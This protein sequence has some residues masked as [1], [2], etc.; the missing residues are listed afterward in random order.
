MSA[1]NASASAVRRPIRL[2]K[3]SVALLLLLLVGGVSVAAAAAPATPAPMTVMRVVAGRVD[4]D[5]P[6]TRR[7]AV[8]SRLVVQRDGQTIAELEVTILSDHQASCRIVRMSAPIAGGDLVVVAPTGQA[9]L[10][11]APAGSA[12]PASRA[13]PAPQADAAGEHPSNQAMIVQRVLRGAVDISLVD[14]QPVAV[15]D[16]LVVERGSLVIGELEVVLMGEH[17]ATCRIDREVRPITQGDRVRRLDVPPPAAAEATAPVAPVP[18]APV[19]PPPAVVEPE[20]TVPAPAVAP[21]VPGEPAVPQ[22][23]RVRQVLAEEIFLD[24]GRS[25]GLAAGQRVKI[26]RADPASGTTSEI[27]ELEIAF[28]ASHSASCKIVSASEP[29]AV[30][31]LVIPGPVPA[32]AA[33]VPA[34]G[35]TG[36]GGASATAPASGGKPPGWNAAEHTDYSG[37]L[38]LRFQGFKDGGPAGRDFNQES[39]LVNIYAGHIGGSKFDFRLRGTAS[40]EQIQLSSG[41]SDSRDNDRL[42]EATLSY[43][44]PEARFTYQVGRLISG[45]LVGFDYLDGGVGE[46]HVTQRFSLGAFYGSRSNGDQIDFAS[47]GRAYGAFVHWLDQGVGRPFYAE[48]LFEAIGDYLHGDTNREYLSFYGRQGSGSRW[49]LY[50]R[51]EF[52]LGHNWRDNPAANSNQLSNVLFSG[53][54]SVSKAVRLGVSYDQSRQIFTLDDRFTPEELFDLAL[55]EGYRV[56]AYLGSAKTV[57]ANFSVGQRWKQGSPDRSLAYNANVYHSNVFGWNM[58]VGGDFSGFDGDTSSGYRAGVRVQKYFRSGHDVELT[59]GRS[60]TDLIATGEVRKNQWLRLSGTLQLGRRF[61]LLG[62]LE[63]ATGDDLEGE[64]LFLQLG[65][66]L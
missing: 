18:V 29:I 42:Y 31:D 53:S 44:P 23:I 66:R 20:P 27:A 54:Y 7:P 8:G 59:Y 52:D 26:V 11:A 64:R 45:P 9:P 39:A 22:A 43:E 36:A 41:G 2:P 49:S 1:W 14:S 56:T 37:S 38:A 6:G 28:I 3:L 47:P 33:T 10:P 32:S 40:R 13:V 61:Y 50:E 46:F 60:S 58:L 51:A 65:Y 24:A 55:R 5:V 21:A 4:V 30:G 48:Y 35:A 17:S 12:S 63:S 57:R 15:G 16:R 19:A 25:S 34:P 62:E